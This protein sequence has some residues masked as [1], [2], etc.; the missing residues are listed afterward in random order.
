[1]VFTT[2]RKKDR[3][4]KPAKLVVHRISLLPSAAPIH[5]GFT[6]HSGA[7]DSTILSRR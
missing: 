5:T 4:D 6:T 7:T 2:L 1:L 3:D